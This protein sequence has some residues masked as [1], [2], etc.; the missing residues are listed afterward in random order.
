MK[1]VSKH[2]YIHWP[3]CHNKCRYCDFIAFEQHEDYQD[4]YHQTLCQEIQSYAQQCEQSHK[5]SI[6]TIFLG[7]GTPS[8]YPLN[9]LTQLFTTLHDN[10]D[11]SDLQEVTIESNPADITEE[12]L[13][14]WRELGI[15]RLSMGIQCLND[16]VLLKLNRRQRT[17]DVLNAIKIAPKYFSNLSVDLILG[18]PGITP[19]SWYDTIQQVTSWPIKHVSIYFLTV[20]EKTPLYFDIQRGLTTLEDDQ[21]VVE[22]YQQTVNLLEKQGFYQY[23]ISNFAKKG[24]T[25]QHNL[26]YWNRKPYKGF[27]IS[28][29]SFDGHE[30][31]TND[32]NLMRYLESGNGSAFYVPCTREILTREQE[33][34]ELLMLDLRQKA[35]FD[36]QRMVYFEGTHDINQFND[37]I[38]QLVN[39]ELLEKKQNTIRLTVKGMV[40]E[41]EIITRLVSCSKPNNNGTKVITRHEVFDI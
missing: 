12:R 33:L 15:N 3:F 27:G 8:L 9:L 20:H 35:G 28:A 6:Q 2:L 5:Q 18:L 10:F 19:P 39:A 26:A 17:K 36:L 21:S 1:N 37:T 4:I 41:N 40:L 7:G 30:R 16:D 34:L 23:E 14:Q 31:T 22:T 13:E 32:N 25:S 24:Y 38:V 11:C 29:S